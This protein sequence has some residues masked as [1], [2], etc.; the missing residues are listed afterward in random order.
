VWPFRP[1]IRVRELHLE[2]AVVICKDNRS[3]LPNAYISLAR[4]SL[5]RGIWKF[6]LRFTQC[7]QHTPGAARRLQSNLVHTKGKV[8][9]RL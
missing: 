6:S 7:R 8:F 9:H 5:L 3:Q 1:L 4:S 2:T